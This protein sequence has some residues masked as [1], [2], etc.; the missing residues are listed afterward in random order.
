MIGQHL[1]CDLDTD[2]ACWTD[3]LAILTT[4]ALRLP[5]EHGLPGLAVDLIA[6]D[7]ATVYAE[8][9]ARTL[10]LIDGDLYSHIDSPAF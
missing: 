3:F 4:H 9:V 5:D 2:R 1:L 10:L 7:G 6:R 8:F